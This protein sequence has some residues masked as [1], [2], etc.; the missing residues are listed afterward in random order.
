[1]RFIGTLLVAAVTVATPLAGAR[2]DAAPAS[3]TNAVRGYFSALGRQD[4]S[5]AIALTNGKAQECTSNMVNKLKS[6]ARAHNAKVEVK[7]TKVDVRAAGAAEARGVP[8]PVN[9]HIDVV[10]KKWCFSKVARQL[11]GQAMF[12][13]DPAHPDRIVAIDGNLE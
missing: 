2:A 3:A 12:W 1:M 11:D 13:L 5:G 4:F 7:V 10:G 6:E 9:F 8:V